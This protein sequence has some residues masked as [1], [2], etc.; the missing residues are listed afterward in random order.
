MGFKCTPDVISTQLL[1]I[2]FF[3]SYGGQAY[4]I[5]NSIHSQSNIHDLIIIIIIKS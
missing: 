3:G 5:L 1:L 4:Y 2:A